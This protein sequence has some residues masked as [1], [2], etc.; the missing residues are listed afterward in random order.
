MTRRTVRIQDENARIVPG[1]GGA[2]VFWILTAMGIAVLTPT[3]LLPEWQ[4]FEKLDLEAQRQAYEVGLLE[5]ELEQQQRLLRAINSDPAVINRLARREL[6]YRN[7]EEVSVPVEAP[8]VARTE[9]KAFDP[10]PPAPPRWVAAFTH[11]LPHLPYDRV[12]SDH[13]LQPIL[14]VLSV[15]VIVIALLLFGTYRRHTSDAEA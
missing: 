6:N 8:I 4:R 14:T 10:T 9:T 11:R 2:L 13:K 1:Q 5:E 7:P 3:V 12:F 15:G